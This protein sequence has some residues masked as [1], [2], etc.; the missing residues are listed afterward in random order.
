MQNAECLGTCRMQKA[1]CEFRMPNSQLTIQNSQLVQLGARLMRQ[2]LVILGV[3]T[4]TIAG[5]CSKPADKPAAPGATQASVPAGD[6]RKYLLET[7][8]DA[9]VVQYYADG[10][11]KL[12]LRDKA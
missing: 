2:T 5:G 9:A 7:V 6:N 10:F 4:T 12:P 8:D 3:V 11:D 1:E